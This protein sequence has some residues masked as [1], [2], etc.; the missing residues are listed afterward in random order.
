MSISIVLPGAMQKQI[1]DL[2]KAQD[3]AI[4][5][6]IIAA[7]Q[8]YLANTPRKI[9]PRE[10]SRRLYQTFKQHL[11]D[12]D[13][14]LSDLSREE[15]RASIEIL[16]QKASAAMPF[17][18]WQEAEAFMRREDHYDFARQQYLHH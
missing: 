9:D 10:R 18:T 8:A 4:D 17:S 11:R 13:A 7:L 14:T 12:F 15:A 5:K 1:Q 2:A 16:S 3:E 6:V